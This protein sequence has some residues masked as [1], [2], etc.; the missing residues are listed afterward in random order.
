M[1]DSMAVASRA[2]RLLDPLNCGDFEFPGQV[3]EIERIARSALAYI[4]ANTDP[5]LGSE[6]WEA[7][8][9]WNRDGLGLDHR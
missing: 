5:S 4:Q 2:V 6:G 3:S 1:I 7:S 8:G 9:D